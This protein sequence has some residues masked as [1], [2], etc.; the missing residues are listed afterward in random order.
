MHFTTQKII[1]GVLVIVILSLLIYISILGMFW[2]RLGWFFEDIWR[3]LNDFTP[4]NIPLCSMGKKILLT[5]E[6]TILPSIFINK[7]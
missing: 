2:T 4:L 5:T 6:I 7:C 3:W 1:L